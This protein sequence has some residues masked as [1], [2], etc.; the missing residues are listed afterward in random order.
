MRKELQNQL[1]EKYPE[2]FTDLGNQET[3]MYWG[4]SCGD[5]WYDILDDLCGTIQGHLDWCNGTGQYADLDRKDPPEPVSQL[6]ATQV[7]EKFGTLRFYARGGDEYCRGA[8]SMA[9]RETHRTCERCGLPGVSR[10][11]GWGAATYCDS[12]SEKCIKE[13]EQRDKEA[14]EYAEKYWDRSD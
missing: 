5:G 13:R 6:K 2:I 14:A 7:K 10:R 1:H 11:I 8:I 9:E 4:L 3:C 12:C